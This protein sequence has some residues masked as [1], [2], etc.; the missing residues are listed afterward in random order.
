MDVFSK[1]LQQ[2]F[3]DY[4]TLWSILGKTVNTQKENA[5]LPERS[6]PTAWASA[7]S[8]YDRVLLSG[9]I[10]FVDSPGNAI[11]SLS[12][13]PLRLESSYRLARKFCHDRFLI[14]GFPGLS[15]E[16][17][18][19][20]LKNCQA[21]LHTA[22]IKW[23]LDIEHSFAG[24]KWRAFYVK[25]AE[26]KKGRTGANKSNDSRHRIY[27]FAEDGFDFRH[28]GGEL[29]PRLRNHNPIGIRQLIDWFMP[30]KENSDQFCLKFFS[31]M[32]LGQ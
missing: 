16:D 25:P 13:K 5:S 6:S 3:D 22:I 28:S 23:V 17:V 26:L 32:A 2:N 21:N 8:N 7:G 14:L 31:R 19:Q 11:F 9:D 10:K 1:C 4:E 15:S 20:H 29:D 24:R 30:S 18:P 27:F 12:L